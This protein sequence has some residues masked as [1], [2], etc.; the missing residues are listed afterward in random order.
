MYDGMQLRAWALVRRGV[1]RLTGLFGVPILHAATN[2]R[3]ERIPHV[4]TFPYCFLDCCFCHGWLCA[5]SSKS[6][7]AYAYSAKQ[8]YYATSDCSE[9]GELPCGMGGGGWRRL[10][11]D[12]RRRK[13]LDGRRG[14]GG[15]KP[16]IPRCARGQRQGRLPDVDWRRHRQFQYL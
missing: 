16:A 13:Y 4:E 15:R 1:A 14:A 10:Y 7:I 9:P 5:R 3:L 6:S 2:P 8:R 11:R 12:Y